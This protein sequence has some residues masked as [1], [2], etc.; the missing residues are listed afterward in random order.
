MDKWIKI[1]VSCK[2]L[3]A[4]LWSLSLTY[5][6]FLQQPTGMF[7]DL[8]QGVYCIDSDHQGQHP[9]IA[10]GS[11]RFIYILQCWA[12]LI[13]S[14]MVVCTIS[15][16]ASRNKLVFF[17]KNVAILGRSLAGLKGDKWC[18]NVEYFI[19]LGFSITYFTLKLIPASMSYCLKHKMHCIIFHF[20][21]HVL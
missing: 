14:P 18:I 17:N 9:R 6:S 12:R 2:L 5:L 1:S 13:K 4:M 16:T 7:V 11:N 19:P 20:N 3:I 15:V 8:P 10:V 21:K